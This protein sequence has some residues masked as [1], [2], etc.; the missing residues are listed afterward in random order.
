VKGWVERNHGLD[1][2]RLVRELQL[3]GISTIAEAN[4]FLE[5]TYLPKINGKFSRAV[6]DPADAHAPLG[7]V[8][9]KGILCFEHERTVINDYAVRFE[10][11]LFQIL[12]TNRVLPQPK[13]SHPAD[14]TGR[15]PEYP[16]ERKNPP[17]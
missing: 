9:L 14:Q 2:E 7:T 3:A 11:C 16:V 12:K 1:Q 4:R 13:Q 8:D 15:Q 10:R 6:A 17:C 5:E